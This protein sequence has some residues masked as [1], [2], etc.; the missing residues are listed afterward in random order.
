MMENI[1]QKYDLFS[2]C[3]FWY[4]FYTVY[5]AFTG[6][7][8]THQQA[9]NEITQIL[10]TEGITAKNYDDIGMT[11]DEF[12]GFEIDTYNYDWHGNAI[13]TL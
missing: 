7:K 8:V 4:N 9:L 12:D 13:L 1:S 10:R 3:I 2:K 11:S 5:S 6:E